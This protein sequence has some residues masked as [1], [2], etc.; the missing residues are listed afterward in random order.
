[1]RVH[2]Y[3][4]SL[5]RLLAVF[6]AL[7]VGMISLPSL[8][9]AGVVIEGSCYA[10]YLQGCVNFQLGGIGEPPGSYEYGYWWYGG[11]QGRIRVDGGLANVKK[12]RNKTWPGYFN[13]DYNE[14][15]SSLCRSRPQDN[16]T[17]VNASVNGLNTTS[18]TTYVPG[19]CIVVY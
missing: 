12:I 13:V 16:K 17:W 2:P 11:D 14:I 10:S 8:A 3:R 18:I 6:L 4:R 1:M 19:Y 15:H 5:L 7:S 9:S